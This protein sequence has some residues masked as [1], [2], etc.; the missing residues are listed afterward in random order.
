MK[1]FTHLK[2]ML[3]EYILLD[4]WRIILH[5]DSF[6]MSLVERSSQSKS[7]DFYCGIYI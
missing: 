5:S 7:T 1:E 6:T 3:V 4:F 2:N